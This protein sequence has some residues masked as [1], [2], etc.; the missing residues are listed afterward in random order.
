V[1]DKKEVKNKFEKK[2]SN[3]LAESIKELTFATAK[4][5]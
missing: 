3:R 5:K 4:T 1:S 2:M